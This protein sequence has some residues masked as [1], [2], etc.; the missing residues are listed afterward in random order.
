MWYW[1]M[2]ILFCLVGV[3]AF[4]TGFGPGTTPSMTNASH[5]IFTGPGSST[6]TLAG[7]GT[8]GAGGDSELHPSATTRAA[9]AMRFTRREWKHA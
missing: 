4:F 3:F 2:C 8:N 7:G 6:T 9:K 5:R 1:M